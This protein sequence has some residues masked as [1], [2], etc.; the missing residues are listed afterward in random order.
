[1]ARAQQDLDPALL[2]VRIDLDPLYSP[3]AEAL[4]ALGRP[5]LLVIGPKPN[6]YLSQH[7]RAEMAASLACVRWVVTEDANFPGQIDLRPQESEW[8]RNL[9][10]VVLTKSGMK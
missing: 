8:L 6:E 4:A 7:A 2:P 9:D 1:M 5:L 10:S 3:Q